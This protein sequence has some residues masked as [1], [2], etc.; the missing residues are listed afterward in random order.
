MPSYATSTRPSIA[1]PRI[2]PRWSLLSL[3][4]LPVRTHPSHA[5]AA[6]TRTLT[7][8][9]GMVAERRGRLLA[10]LGSLDAKSLATEIA[11]VLWLL[12]LETA[13]A[14]Y[15]LDKKARGPELARLRASEA[16]TDRHAARL[17][18]DWLADKRNR[19]P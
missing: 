18:D 6:A 16:L 2:R 1:S 5:A 7:G 10:D 17:V 9:A 13:R 3:P 11:A 15:A 19:T 14:V 8:L 12:T 4:G